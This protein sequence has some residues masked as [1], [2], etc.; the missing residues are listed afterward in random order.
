MEVSADAVKLGAIRKLER[1]VIAKIAAG[2]VIQRPCNVIKEM[3]ENSIDAH[4]TKIQ[5]SVKDGGLKSISITDDGDGIRVRFSPFLVSTSV[6]LPRFF[7]DTLRYLQKEDLVVVCE[8]FTTSKLVTFDDLRSIATFGFRGEALASI[9]QVAHVTITSK[10]KESIIGYK[11]TYKD[12]KLN[13]RNGAESSDPQPC[14]ST[15]GT[16]FLVDDLFY[17]YPLRKTS[18]SAS[19]EYARIY[20]VV[21]RYALHFA[22]VAFNLKKLGENKADVSTKKTNTHKDNIRELFGTSIARDLIPIDFTVGEGEEIFGPVP[23][24]GIAFKLSGF[25]SG[26]TASPKKSIFVLFINNRLVNLPSLKKFLESQYSTLM[27]KSASFMYLSLHIHPT[28]IDVNLHPSK[29]E[30]GLIDQ[31]AI[32]SKIGEHFV[33]EIDKFSSEHKFRENQATPMAE[34]TVLHKTHASTHLLS[35]S[36]IAATIVRSDGREVSID[37]YLGPRKSLPP[38]AP[39]EGFGDPVNDEPESND[40]L[41]AA[42][43]NTGAT[44]PTASALGG[45]ATN[46]DSSARR[47]SLVPASPSLAQAS[48]NTAFGRGNGASGDYSSSRATTERVMIQRAP[49]KAPERASR[50]LTSI[51]EILAEIERAQLHSISKVIHDAKVVGSISS[52][53]L[54]VQAGNVLYLLDMPAFSTELVYQECLRRIGEMNSFELEEAASISGLIELMVQF[55]SNRPRTTFTSPKDLAAAC[56]QRLVERRELLQTYFGIVVSAD[57]LLLALPE[58]VAGYM[59]VLDGLP[60]FCYN[61]ACKVDWRDEKDTFDRVAREIALLYAIPAE[62]EPEDLRNGDKVELVSGGTSWA[63]EHQILPALKV[64]FCPPPSLQESQALVTVVSTEKLFKIF[65]RC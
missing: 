55:S 36:S 47:S 61:L 19:D 60:D 31:Q 28:K 51:E 35:T 26:P 4:A 23:S 53:K 41:L 16:Q 50:L 33:A 57:G 8:R 20:D 39:L 18:M 2:E 40:A 64:R 10:H 21:T 7:T 1:G 46:L 58:V 56:A 11:A 6:Q 48:S 5:I 37:A 30:V 3:L 43:A 34:D 49:S 63:V 44:V 27:A 22:G 13:A 52:R 62:E 45:S 12:G 65:E 25:V 38:T 32:I 15:P 59:P 24:T 9:S 29:Q 14:A 42:S 54:L 17:N